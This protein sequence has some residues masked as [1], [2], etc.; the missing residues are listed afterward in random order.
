MEMAMHQVAFRI[1]EMHPVAFTIP[2]ERAVGTDTPFHPHP[3]A[4]LLIRLRYCDK[5]I[6]FLDIFFVYVLNRKPVLSGV[7]YERD[8]I[9]DAFVKTVDSV[10]I[11]FLKVK[12]IAHI[13]GPVTSP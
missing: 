8:L 4:I 13:P 9:A 5:N 3:V 7:E 12:F 1:A 6:V 2:P 11:I 10:A